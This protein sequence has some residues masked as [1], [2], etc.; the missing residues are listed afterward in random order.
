MIYELIGQQTITQRFQTLINSRRIGSAYL[1]SGPEGAGKTSMAL[2][3]AARLLCEDPQNGIACGSCRSCTKMKHLNH[4]NLHIIHAMPRGKNPNDNDPYVG[5]SE[6]DFTAMQDERDALTRDPY[7]GINL[8]GANQILIS[9]VRHIKKELAMKPA[10]SGRQVVLVFKAEMANVQALNSLLKILEEPPARTTFILTT[11]AIDI[12]PS[13][14]R[15]RCQIVKFN[16]VPDQQLVDYLVEQGQ[17]ISNARRIARLSGGNVQHAKA[18]MEAD[19]TEV[20]TMILDF[21]RIMMGGKIGGRWVT[22][23]DITELIENYA[24][25]AKSDPTGFRNILRF[26]V[27]WLR[28]AQFLASVPETET[29]DNDQLINTHLIT[30]LMAFVNY[31]PGFPYFEMIRK[32]EDVLRDSK[33]NMYMPALLADLFLE[34]RTALLEKRKAP[35]ATQ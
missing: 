4:P 32:I 10:E 21:W 25:M 31:Y 17:D 7:R 1:F 33:F 14:I 11:S 9:S 24:G 16:P 23:A 6:A 3:L 13:T 26:M 27:F 28:D 30:E 22:T 34:L 35:N 2:N 19:F 29:A 5:L 8:P 15:S 18:L 20:D 12:L